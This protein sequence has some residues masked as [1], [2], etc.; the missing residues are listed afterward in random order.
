MI[1]W[2]SPHRHSVV[3][4]LVHFQ[5]RSPSGVPLLSIPGVSR[6]GDLQA[7][8]WGEGRQLCRPAP[9]GA[10]AVTEKDVRGQLV[11]GVLL[12]CALLGL[13]FLLLVIYRE[14]ML[15]FIKSFLFFFELTDR[16]MWFFIFRLPIW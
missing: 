13:I 1:P 14:W 16:S 10:P 12:R 5:S 6:G 2:N 8:R 11:V 7:A 15:N 3:C 9:G 4:K